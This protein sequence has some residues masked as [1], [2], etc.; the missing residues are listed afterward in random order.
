[1]PNY[2]NKYKHQREE[3]EIQRMLEE[4]RAKIPPGTRLMPDDER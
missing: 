2:I 3:A 4:E 1:V